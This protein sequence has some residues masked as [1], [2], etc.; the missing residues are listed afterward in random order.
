MCEVMI[1]A[2]TYHLYYALVDA[3]SN[4][5]MH[6]R[7]SGAVPVMSEEAAGSSH[8]LVEDYV[9]EVERLRNMP[10]SREVDVRTFPH[11]LTSP[12][13]LATRTPNS[14]QMQ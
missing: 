7:H 1:T 13:N 14:S 9:K 10:S 5:P 8:A 6:C 12:I 2:S 11:S 3:W 4:F